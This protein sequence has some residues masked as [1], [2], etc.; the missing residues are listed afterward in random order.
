MTLGLQLQRQH[1]FVLSDALEAR[2]RPKQ[3]PIGSFYLPFS[4]EIGL[5]QEPICLCL[6]QG[7]GSPHR[8][9]SLPR[10]RAVCQGLTPE[11]ASYRN[12]LTDRLGGAG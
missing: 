2:R 4:H 6:R 11:G 9:V 1:R 7:V 3:R 10:P 8:I 12:A 5:L